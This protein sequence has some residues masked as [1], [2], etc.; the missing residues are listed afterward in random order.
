MQLFS[1]AASFYF[2]TGCVGISN[3]RFSKLD[4]E[5]NNFNKIVEE[6]Y[7]GEMIVEKNFAYRVFPLNAADSGF[8]IFPIPFPF[9]ESTPIDSEFSVGISLKPFCTDLRFDP[10]KVI[11]WTDSSTKYL[12]YGFIG[13]Y[14]CSSSDTRPIE[15]KLPVEPIM[16]EDS[17]TS[18]FWIKF[19]TIVPDPKKKLHFEIKGLSINGSEVVI[20]EIVF[21]QAK[22]R[23]LFSLP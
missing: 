19:K 5:N 7:V 2:I 20:P 13:P 21:K 12:P 22:R 14:E 17:I 18:C 4:L 16:L 3:S 15:R 23:E 8:L 6:P 10:Q 11:F 9:S 1:I